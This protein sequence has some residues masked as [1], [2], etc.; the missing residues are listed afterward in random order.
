MAVDR[1]VHTVEPKKHALF[2][3]LHINWEV[4]EGSLFSV[5]RESGSERRQDKVLKVTPL[6]N[7]SPCLPRENKQFSLT[8]ATDIGG[9]PRMGYHREKHRWVKGFVCEPPH[10]LSVHRI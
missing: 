10:G 7:R 9:R 1:A 5:A 8:E 3:R 6:P 2:L 4:T